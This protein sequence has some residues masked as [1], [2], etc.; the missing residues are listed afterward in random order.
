VKGVE[1]R[2]EWLHRLHDVDFQTLEVLAHSLEVCNL[3]RSH[4]GQ[5][6]LIGKF[7]CH[8]AVLSQPFEGS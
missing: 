3:L 5:V 8:P 1:G 4:C 2:M 7:R 6:H